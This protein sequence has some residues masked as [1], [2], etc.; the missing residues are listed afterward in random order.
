[1]NGI[2]SIAEIAQVVGFIASI[3]GIIV[4]VTPGAN[5]MTAW[6]L[7]FGGIFCFAIGRFVKGVAE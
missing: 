2:K 6:H 1:M 5:D 4:A 3:A 7:L